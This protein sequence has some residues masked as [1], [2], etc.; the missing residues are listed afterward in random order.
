M[1]SAVDR[2]S[3]LAAEHD[4]HHGP[5]PQPN[6]SSRVEAQFLGMLLFIISEVMPP[7][8]RSFTAY[9]FIRVV[10][11]DPWPAP[12]H[13]TCRSSWRGSNTGILG[14]VV[15]HDP[16]G[17]RVRPP[18]ATAPACAR[19]LLTTFMLGL[20]FPCASRSTS[21]CTSAFAPNTTAPRGTIFYCL[22]GLHGAPRPS[23]ASTLLLFRR[24]SAPFPRP[25]HAEGSTAV[26]RCRGIYWHFV[27]VMWIIVYSTVYIL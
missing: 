12:R 23:S 18:E 10:A 15:V 25:L 5:A 22:T 8:E 6:Q 17:A 27:D 24:P 26:S 9:F 14:L 4:E 13:A 16:L 1:E 2:A 19:A 21:T 3:S 20:T 7:S 11:D